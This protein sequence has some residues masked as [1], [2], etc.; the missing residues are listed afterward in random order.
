MHPNANS[1]DWALPYAS[2]RSA[3]MGRNVVSTSQPLAAQA[4]LRMLLAGGTQEEWDANKAGVELIANSVQFAEDLITLQ[5]AGDAPLTFVGADE[6]LSVETPAGW[7][8][9]DSNDPTLPIIVGAPDM[10]FA[11]AVGTGATMGQELNLSQAELF[12]PSGGESNPEDYD[13]LV[14]AIVEMLGS[15]GQD[16]TLNPDLQTVYE[17]DGG[18]T[19]R[20]VGSM[21]LDQDLPFTVGLYIDLRADSGAILIV[22][23]DIDAAL[24]QEDALRAVVESATDLE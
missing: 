10:S 15:S 7:Y 11:A 14:D 2:H 1:L 19:I 16:L 6:T 5:Q 12:A 22:F 23:G 13:D 18:L 17:R 9:S 4:G 3:V 24:A 8:V 20:L 21:D